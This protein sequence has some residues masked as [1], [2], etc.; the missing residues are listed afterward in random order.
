MTR[1]KP[2]Q[3]SDRAPNRRRRHE[4]TGSNQIVSPVSYVR[5]INDLMS[6]AEQA[7]GQFTEPWW[8]GHGRSD[9]TLVPS[10]YR[11]QSTWNEIRFEQN[12]LG[13]FVQRART[14]HSPCPPDGDFAAWLYL[15]QHYRL[16]TRILDWTESILIAA[17]F[18]VG[19][20]EIRR[21]K[22]VVSVKWWKSVSASSSR[23]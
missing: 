3:T 9:W 6:A 1:K 2:R 23:T 18:A 8:R 21:D 4:R 20:T 5:N 10:V 11:L 14:R 7:I 12:I 16:P 22:E 13:R 15:A 17:F 19:F